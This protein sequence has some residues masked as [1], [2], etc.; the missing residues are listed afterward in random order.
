LTY[1]LD[2]KADAFGELMAQTAPDLILSAD[3]TAL[4][5]Y[6]D[7]VTLD[8]DIV[9]AT[10][11]NPDGKPMTEFTPPDEEEN[12]AEKR[13][14]I[15]FDGDVLGYVVIGLSQS[16]LNNQITLSD[17]RIKATIDHLT[18][19]GEKS[20]N[21]FS[22][23]LVSVIIAA[24]AFISIGMFLLFHFIVAKRLKATYKATANSGDLT[25]QLPD[26]E[27]DEIGQLR[28]SFNRYIGELRDTIK[29][30]ADD[31]TTLSKVTSELKSSSDEQTE[32]ANIQV[33]ESIYV[34]D[35]MNEMTAS[36]REVANITGG[37]ANA[38]QDADTAAHNGKQ[39]VS[40]TVESI[41]TLA[42]EVENTANVV[43]AL[44]SNSENIGSVLDVIRSVADQTNL[45]A[46]NAAIEAARAGEQGRGF[47]VVADEV[48]TLASRTQESTEE[49]Q[50]IILQLQNDS[51]HAVKAMEK[52]RAQAQASV[53]QA[54]TAGN[55]LDEITQSVT[56]IRDMNSQI[57][58]AAEEQTAR[59]EEVKRNV[60]KINEVTELSSRIT[61]RTSSASE[62]LSKVVT[63]LESI[64]GKFRLS[65]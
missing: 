56:T 39:V 28:K 2:S 6:R 23:I 35:A 29:M 26:N 5:Y 4:E 57:A 15:N 46:L 10:Y 52:G 1:A 11:L 64:I 18:K 21:R 32:N 63:R 17:Q 61:E 40:K 44:Q 24:M 62:H 30:L 20:V 8:D 13:Y 49:I 65:A 48:R 37:A 55:S 22:V 12:I 14:P 41:N 19:T 60:E 9:Y 38:A 45:L 58:S 27:E 51:V 3:F 54:A 50:Q 59:A 43:T 53:A 34:S 42:E 31:V 7:K 47:A 33:K 16:N 25:I 36:A